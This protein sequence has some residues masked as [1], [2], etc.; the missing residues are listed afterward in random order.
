MPL[1]SALLPITEN[2]PCGNNLRGSPL[3]FDM[4]GAKG[5]EQRQSFSGDGTGESE[6]DDAD[7]KLVKSNAL[8]LLDDTHDI[9]ISTHLCIALLHTDGFSGL[10]DGLQ[11]IRSLLEQFWECVHP[12]LDTDYPEDPALERINTLAELGGTDFIRSLRKHPVISVRTIGTY[13]INDIQAAHSENPPEGTPKLEHIDGAFTEAGTGVVKGIKEAVDNAIAEAETIENIFKEKAG[14]ISYPDF[15]GLCS[16]LREI[17]FVLAGK[18]Q[19]EE[20]ETVENELDEVTEST[21]NIT[22]NT[23][24]FNAGQINNREDVVKAIDKICEYYQNHEPSS[25]VPMI[26]KR[27]RRLVDKDFIEILEDLSP[28]NTSQALNIL[29]IE[30][31]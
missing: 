21:S 20:P 22:Q 15:S 14:P 28:D 13:N 17:S 27:A 10:A 12:E 4:L 2:T 29:G 8:S 18:L 6:E 9:E 16:T 31:T 24:K 7:W 1:K 23:P 19:D 30:N 5:G 26:L 3:Y 25:P 11:L